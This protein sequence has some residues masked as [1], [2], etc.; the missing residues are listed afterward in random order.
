M[1]TTQIKAIGQLKGMSFDTSILIGTE[2]V[3]VKFVNGLAELPQE[4]A[5]VYENIPGFEI[6]G[7]KKSDLGA[8][9]PKI[10][11][12]PIEIEKQTEIAPEPKVE[13]KVEPITDP[14]EVAKEKPAKKGGKTTTKGK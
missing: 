4:V 1:K 10:E 5:K 6:V 13:A 14:V 11:V 3:P 8:D 7:A 2:N 9:K 12:K